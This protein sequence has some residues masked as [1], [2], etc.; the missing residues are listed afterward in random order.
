[1]C[2]V[3]TF[4]IITPIIADEI[5]TTECLKLL[6]G[7]WVNDEYQGFGKWGKQVRYEDGRAD[8][9]TEVS[10]IVPVRESRIIINEAWTDSEE[11]VWFKVHTFSG[12]YFE[13]ADPANYALYKLGNSQNVLEYI[14]SFH[15]YPTEIDP[16]HVLYLI[17]YRQE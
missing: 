4:F 9:Y 8:L 3:L 2:F 11:N 5:S 14:S 7:T 1:M 12:S 13:G 17:Y 15:D 16:D 6:S 10:A